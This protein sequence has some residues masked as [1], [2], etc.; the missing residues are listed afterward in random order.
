MS[1]YDII[2]NEAAFGEL[3][4]NRAIQAEKKRDQVIEAARA[5]L[6]DLDNAD[7]VRRLRALTS[8]EGDGLSVSSCAPR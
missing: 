2:N 8:E 6:I 5:L 7:A 3:M 4:K 1:L